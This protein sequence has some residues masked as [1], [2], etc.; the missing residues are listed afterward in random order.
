MDA[1]HSVRRL[2]ASISQPAQ[3]NDYKMRQRDELV[4]QETNIMMKGARLENI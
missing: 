1:R 3:T 2:D 4:V